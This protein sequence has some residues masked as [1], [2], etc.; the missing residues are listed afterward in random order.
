MRRC[1]T[2]WPRLRPSALP[3][4]ALALAL[5]GC[6]SLGAY[7]E[8]E[9]E[10][11]RI[12]TD[13]DRLAA[14]VEVLETSNETLLEERNQVL[15][16]IEDLRETK[17]K[18]DRDVVTLREAHGQLQAA[19]SDR[20]ARL[21]EREAELGARTE[22]LAAQEQEIARLRATYDALVSD[23]ESEVE[24]KREA[25]D[26]LRGGETMAFPSEALFEPE[27]LEIHARGRGV[28]TGLAERLARLPDRVEVHGHT[29]LVPVSGPLA[30][31]YPSNWEVA[32]AM[33]AGVARV[34]VE[35]G[36]DP[37]RVIAVSHGAQVPV[38]SNESPETR[39]QNRRI[40]IRLVPEVGG[41]A[42]GDAARPPARAAAPARPAP[43]E[44][45]APR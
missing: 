42:A 19:L 40:E 44:A 34:L 17:Q 30:Q 14:R 35:A 4:A 45:A 12:A 11:D 8:L 23:L 9:E 32:G 2:R 5:G 33:A 36:V 29:A 18:L 28:L 24:A 7:D 38:A 27:S 41:A 31:L 43:A 25:I 37:R 15:G 21:T 3:V 10:R 16:E 26:R 22:A 20:E 1:L 6:V 13:R 39:A